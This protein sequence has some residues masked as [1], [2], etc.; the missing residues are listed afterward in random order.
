MHN[1][2]ALT[3]TTH[4]TLVFGN[5]GTSLLPGHLHAP[6]LSFQNTLGFKVGLLKQ[7]VKAQVSTH[8]PH[9]ETQSFDY[10]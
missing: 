2:N 7:F 4:S 9:S 5:P 1:A 10:S 6:F 8:S 3:Q